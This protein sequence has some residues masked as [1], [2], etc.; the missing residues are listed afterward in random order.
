M[1]GPV[2][3]SLNGSPATPAMPF[4]L[5]PPA[6]LLTIGLLAV[7]SSAASAD[8]RPAGGA[9]AVAAQAD[10]ASLGE[11]E[12]LATAEAADRAVARQEAM[13]EAAGQAYESAVLNLAN[14]QRR[15]DEVRHLQSEA[16][17]QAAERAVSLYM[18]PRDEPFEH[19][20]ASDDLNRGVVRRALSVAVLVA[21][22]SAADR[23]RRAERDLR[24]LQS[25]AEAAQAQIGLV[26][27]RR[28]A[29]SGALRD[30]V[31]RQVRVAS[32][33][34]QRID[35]AEAESR[36]LAD[37]EARILE[38]IHESAAPAIGPFVAG[39]GS[40]SL[41]VV[42]PVTS[43]FGLR[44]GSM[45]NGIDFGADEGTPVRAAA[46]GTVIGAEYTS[47]FGLNVIIDHGNG[48]TTLYAHLSVIGVTVGQALT[49]G[50]YLGD[51]GSTGRSTGS[52]LHLE[53]RFDGVAHDP[54]EVLALG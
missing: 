34:R 43:E 27:Q 21:H 54:R 47:G 19:L 45:H 44:W 39:P 9:V 16:R 15:L 30:T 35:A 46:A 11:R 33:L 7:P 36:E 6:L 49:R 23:L 2:V 40:L 50:E 48:F 14:L 4:R 52:H 5:R 10:P 17:R 3:R 12:L 37:G 18:N 24:E 51:V 22:Q 32:T 42:A 26:D 25:A 53:T 1:A 28:A 31:E 8:A 13:V 20:L 41:P 29:T 38:V